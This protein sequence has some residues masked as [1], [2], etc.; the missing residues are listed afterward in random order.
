[1]LATMVADPKQVDEALL[2]AWAA[3][4]DHY[5][6]TDAF[7]GLAGQ[8]AWAREK[9]TAWM[10]AEDEWLG[11]AGWGLL[12]HLAMKDDPLPDACFEPFFEIVEQR[13]HGAKNRVR[14]AMNNALIAMGTRSEA[15]EARALAAARR[16]GPVHVDHGQTSCRTPD[17]ATYLPKARTHRRKKRG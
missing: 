8:T 1:M 7:T 3:D 14:Y 4:L 10:D 6:L 16:I 2:D 12:A 17:A 5:V 13:I 15:L 11:S 9:M